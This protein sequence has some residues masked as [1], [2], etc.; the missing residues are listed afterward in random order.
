MIQNFSRYQCFPSVGKIYDKKRKR[1][2]KGCNKD[3][4]IQVT[5]TNDEGEWKHMR[6][7]RA[8]LM[9]YMGEGIPIGLEVNHIDEDKL[10]NKIK[11]L[12]LMTHKDNMNWGTHNDRVGKARINNPK[13]SKRVQAFDKEGNLVFDFPSAKEAQR[14][15]GFNNSNISACCIGK[16]KSAYGYTWKYA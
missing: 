14:Q 2:V 1:F 15:M 13:I 5:L 16:S 8:I 4:Y 9:S 10:N 7:H 12:N 6:F 3:G 11:N